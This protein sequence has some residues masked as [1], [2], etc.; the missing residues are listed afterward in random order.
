L[1]WVADQLDRLDRA[2]FPH[3]I[4]FFHHPIFTSGPHSGIQPPDPATHERGPDRIEP[5]TL[6]LRTLYAP[7]FR[8]HHVRMTVSGHDHLFDHWVERYVDGGRAYRRDDVLSGGGGAPIYT[9][10]GEPQL[11]AYLKGAADQ[12]VKLQHLAKPGPN[13][14]DNPHHFV[15]VDVDSD[16]LSIEVVPVS[17]PLAPYNGKTTIDLN[18]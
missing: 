17:G 12:Q 11:E 2:R 14:T 8:K 9:Y 1:A 13:V 7:L 6:A 4:V 15:I 18:P 16:K 10:Q 5:S 3:V